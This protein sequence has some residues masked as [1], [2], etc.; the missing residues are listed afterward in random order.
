MTM[1]LSQL[2]PQ[3]YTKE[4]LEKIEKIK[5]NLYKV[6]GEKVDNKTKYFSSDDCCTS[7]EERRVKSKILKNSVLKKHAKQIQ[8]LPPPELPIHLKNLINVLDG[9]DIKYVMCKTLFN[10]D[11]S[12]YN[13]RLS[14]PLSQIKSD[15]LTEIEKATLNTKDQ[16][17]KPVGLEVIVL[18]PNHKEFAMSLKKWNMNTTSVYNIVQN[19]TLI[20]KENKF[21]E[22]QKV[23][24]WSFRVNNKL[25]IL[26]DTYVAP[27]IE[28]NGE[29]NE[30]N[31][32]IIEE[33]NDED[34]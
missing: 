7:Y 16:Q 31:E 15:F 1:V 27:E 20:L 34:C 23:N 24:I 30:N 21:K 14:M 9:R 3:Y 32:R 5:Q 4:E 25:H 8:P 22:K 17:D 19:W 26:L 29:L 28:E 33:E 13:N 2:A 18:D 12:E 11:L 10:S 6:E